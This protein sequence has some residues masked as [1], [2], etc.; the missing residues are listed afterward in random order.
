M[1]LDKAL[2]A[3]RGELALRSDISTCDTLAWCLFKSGRIEEARTA[4]KEAMRLGTRDAQIFYH[5]GMIYAALGDRPNAAR[6]LSL[7]LEINPSF[8]LLQSD[9]AM[10]ARDNIAGQGTLYDK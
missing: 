1:H 7:A 3:A 6:Y 2:E 10:Q 5:A 9:I 8:D 4:I